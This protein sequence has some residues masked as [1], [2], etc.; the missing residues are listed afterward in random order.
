MG[1][2]VALWLSAREYANLCDAVSKLLHLEEGL[3]VAFLTF[4]IGRT[5]LCNGP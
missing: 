5:K 3:F 4:K 1:L 2:N